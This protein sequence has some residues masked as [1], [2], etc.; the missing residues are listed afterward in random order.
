VLGVARGG[1]K[2]GRHCKK[3]TL[4]MTIEK[5][6]NFQVF[7][8][9]RESNPIKKEFSRKKPSISRPSNYFKCKAKFLNRIGAYINM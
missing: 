7:E 9:K 1:S 6:R 4:A 3:H 2:K 8:K 5:K